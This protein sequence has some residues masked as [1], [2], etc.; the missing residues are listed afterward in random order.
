[1]SDYQRK[2]MGH[3]EPHTCP[4]SRGTPCDGCP[5]LACIEQPWRRHSRWRCY[6]DA[7]GKRVDPRAV[8]CPRGRR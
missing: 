8:E 2:A 4:E 3:E 5:W 7:L 1:M 6:C